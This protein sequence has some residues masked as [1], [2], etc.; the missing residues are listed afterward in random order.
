VF[1]GSCSCSSP[2][3]GRR[4]GESIGS[5]SVSRKPIGGF[6]PSGSSCRWCWVGGLG[7]RSPPEP[8]WPWPRP[9][10]AR[11]RCDCRWREKS[12][13]SGFSAWVGAHWPVGSSISCRRPIPVPD[14]HRRHRRPIDRCRPGP[15]TP[16]PSDRAASWKGMPRNLAARNHPLLHNRQPSPTPEGPRYRRRLLYRFRCPPSRVC[17]SPRLQCRGPNFQSPLL[18]H[19]PHPRSPNTA[20]S[21]SIWEA[22]R[23]SPVPGRRWGS[24]PIPP[25]PHFPSVARRSRHH[26]RR[27]PFHLA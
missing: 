6:S 19:R 11:T 20:G 23:T 5:P 24:P 14:T 2:W 1:F 12:W 21:R 16:M 15:R 22:F 26:P 9:W 27:E 3:W 25:S 10:W 18:V 4:V 7:S 8:S 13:D 17:S